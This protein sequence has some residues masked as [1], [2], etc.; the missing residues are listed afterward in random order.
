MSRI[1]VRISSRPQA[2]SAASRGRRVSLRGLFLAVPAAL[3][4]M[5]PLAT[6]ALAQTSSKTESG[7][8]QKAPLP[9]TEKKASSGVAPSSESSKP[10]S[11]TTP[12]AS[13]ASPNS[14]STLPFTGLDLRWVIGAGLLLIGAGFSIRYLQRRERHDIGR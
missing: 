5:A 7:Y 10:T 12:T 8:G 3:M 1:D 14:S 2:T 6:P 11:S 4:L 13:A 9:K